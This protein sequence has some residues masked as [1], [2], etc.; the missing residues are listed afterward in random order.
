MRD[1]TAQR[2]AALERE[3]LLRRE[4]HAR[5]EAE[6]A[7]RAKDE[8]LATVSHELRTPL[9]AIL[10]WSY[11]LA[12][13]QLDQ[14]QQNRAVETIARNARAQAQLVADLLD[15]SR[16]VA[17]RFQISRRSLSLQPIMQKAVDSVHPSARSRNVTITTTTAA[18]V[19][20]IDGDPDR[21]QQ[22]I[23]NLL[24]NAIKFTPPGGAIDVRLERHEGDVQL[25]VRDTGQGIS[26]AEL[27]GIFDRF[28]QAGRIQGST[29]GLGLGLAIARHIVEA[30]GGAI[31]AKSDGEGTGATFVVRLPRAAGNGIPV[32]SA[33]TPAVQVERVPEL[34]G[35]TAL[36]VE[37]QI[38][39]QQLAA[40]VLERC[41]IRVFTADS[42]DSALDI[43]DT[44]SIDVLVSD[45]RLATEKDG[46]DL[47]RTVRARP[48]PLGRVPAI[49][50][51]AF[52]NVDD[53]A[54]ALSAGYQQHVAKPVAPPDL[55]EAVKALFRSRGP[56]V[57]GAEAGS[58][59]PG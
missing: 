4:L 48:D 26:P 53:Q 29:S 3:E 35:R 16:I 18:S 37:D 7:N 12:A 1:R 19:P 24:S 20:P 50:V 27:P 55:V 11:V 23:L 2:E 43:L 47:I 6:E 9:N 46:L 22:V 40:F 13:G 17:G 45:V 30:H 41:G 59:S 52:A 36:V 5:K 25:V 32:T 56:E 21:L 51:S 54:R 38:D 10:G 28:K 58:A 39:S 14:A 15:V 31:D 49:V 44:Q 42:Y 57:D 8:F 33:A 34:A